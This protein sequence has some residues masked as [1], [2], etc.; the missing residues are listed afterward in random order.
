MSSVLG[1][2][3]RQTTTRSRHSILAEVI[4]SLQQRAM[5]ACGNCVAAG[6]VCWFSEEA[7]SRCSA[8]VKHQRKN[9]NGTFV[10][11][12]FRKV[13]EQKK[14]AQQQRAAKDKE[15]R[16]QRSN[17]LRAQRFFSE[18]QRQLADLQKELVV[19]QGELG[20]EQEVLFKKQ[21]EFA[22]LEEQRDLLDEQVLE[23]EDKSSKMLRREMQVLGVL[24]QLPASEPVV[25]ANPDFDWEG[26]PISEVVD[27]NN[28]FQGA[29]VE[30][31]SDSPSG[32]I[33]VRL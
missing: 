26:A 31:L 23:L 19:L 30:S 17:L 33:E 18:R 6:D 22:L 2:R 10:L 5:V 9:C 3:R 21:E 13:V 1:K 28:V 15:L 16:V 14:V 20:G 24:D 32:L 11:E 8:C 4:E 27:W 7:S 25:L 29:S 12:E